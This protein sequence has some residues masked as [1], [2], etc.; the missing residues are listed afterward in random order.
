MRHQKVTLI[1]ELGPV[2]SIALHPRSG[3]TSA[4]VEDVNVF[5][6]FQSEVAD[7]KKINHISIAVK[8]CPNIVRYNI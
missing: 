2:G 1:I 5:Y 7:D 8:R 4:I 3:L 6:L